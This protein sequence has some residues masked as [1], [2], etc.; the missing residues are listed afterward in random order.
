MPD[1]FPPGP[2]GLANPPSGVL[3]TVDTAVA[4]ACKCCLPGFVPRSG[5]SDLQRLWHGSLEPRRPGLCCQV[6]DSRDG[7]VSEGNLAM[8][9]PDHNGVTRPRQ[10]NSMG[11]HHKFRPPVPC[12]G[13]DVRDND[14]STSQVV[15][16]RDFRLML[17][18]PCTKYIQPAALVF[19]PDRL[20]STLP[21]RL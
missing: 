4:L 14:K 16:V 7:E 19:R 6:G 21:G 8:A 10:M 15:T 13:V 1:N 3:H 20:D 17:C 2:T 12:C 5:Q 18:T 11:K 9:A